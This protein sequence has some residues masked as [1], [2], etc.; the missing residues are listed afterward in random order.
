MTNVFIDGKEGTTGLQIYERLSKRNDINLITLAES[1]RKDP[2]KR[3]EALNS[4][5]IA[6]LCL[7]DSAAVESAA[8]VENRYV[9][10]LI[11]VRLRTAVPL[12]ARR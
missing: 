11:S 8:M 1:D 7:P 3:K 4:C 9:D 12:R 10:H 6:F 2:A 5:D